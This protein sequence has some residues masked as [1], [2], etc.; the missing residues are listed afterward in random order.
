MHAKAIRAFEVVVL[1]VTVPEI[2]TPSRQ[3]TSTLQPPIMSG[4]RPIRSV[5]KKATQTNTMRSELCG[6]KIC[7]SALI[8]EGRRLETLQDDEIGQERILHPGKG[9]EV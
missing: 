1:L 5:V 9:K 6:E 2:P 4:R 7:S 3:I 8:A